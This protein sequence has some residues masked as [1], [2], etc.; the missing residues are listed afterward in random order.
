M[1]INNFP[2]LNIQGYV[3]RQITAAD[4]DNIYAGL[5]NPDVIKYYGVSFKTLAE[6]QQ[7]MNWYENLLKEGTGIWWAIEDKM[8]K[9][10]CGAVGLNNMNKSFKNAE[11]GYWLLPQYWHQGIMQKAVQEILFY[12][13]N[14]LQLHRIFAHIETENKASEALLQ[15]CGFNYEGTMQD[16]E[17]KNG[18][19]I[20]IKIY[21]ML[22]R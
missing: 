4:I 11:L 13:L 5:S 16:C 3:L 10:F 15:R 1:S 21:A 6:T 22:N 18:I 8:N 7:Q 19:Y 2:L 17:I 14:T 12:A 9:Q 20:S